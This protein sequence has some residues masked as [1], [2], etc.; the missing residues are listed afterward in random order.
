MTTKRRTFSACSSTHPPP[1]VVRPW[2]RDQPGQWNVPKNASCDPPGPYPARRRR[3]ALQPKHSLGLS[4]GSRSWMTLQNFAL[5]IMFMVLFSSHGVNANH[6]HGG[7]ELIF[8][9]SEPPVPPMRLHRRDET[10]SVLPSSIAAPTSNSL[11]STSATSSGASTI[12]TAGPSSSSPLPSPF[13]S[14]LGNNFT[15]SSCPNFFQSFL[16]N[17][18]FQKC[19]PLSLLL[20][21]RV[22]DCPTSQIWTNQSVDI[23]RLLRS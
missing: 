12:S 14:S 23:Q 17:S 18:T 2:L 20:Q 5:A 7:C 19:H 1:A 13:D 10:T 8:D 15:A 3:T 16:S 11:A 4:A 6:F 22:P 21:V 9:R